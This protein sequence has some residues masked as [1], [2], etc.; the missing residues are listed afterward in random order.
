MNNTL[1]LNQTVTAGGVKT[2][3]ISGTAKDG[4]GTGI[5]SVT[6]TLSGDSEG[7][8]VTS[9]GGTWSFSG[10]VD[11]TYTVTPSKSGYTFS[12]EDAEVVISGADDATSDF[13]GTAVWTVSGDIVDGVDAGIEG[14]LVTLSGDAD[15]TD[16]TDVNGHYE[17]TGLVDG[18]YTVTPTLAN[19]AFVDASE[20]VVI[21]GG[22]E[23]VADMVGAQ[24]YPSLPIDLNWGDGSGLDT[25][26]W[27][28]Q[29]EPSATWVGNIVTPAYQGFTPS[30]AKSLRV[31]CAGDSD[32]AIAKAV[33]DGLRDNSL[34]FDKSKGLRVQFTA[35]RIEPHDYFKTYM[36]VYSTDDSSCIL[37]NY[38]TNYNNPDNLRLIENPEGIDSQ[39]SV[40][41]DETSSISSRWYTLRL[42]IDAGFV[43]ATASSAHEAGAFTTASA[44]ISTDISSVNFD[45][46]GVQLYRRG[47]GYGYWN[48]VWIGTAS[49]AWPAQ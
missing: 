2:W 38:F 43:N 18:S 34:I 19:Y 14:V 23:T 6:L 3:T 1:L 24:I 35:A 25:N 37:I 32:A 49:D 31:Q 16:T 48:R 26:V 29:S 28:D 33:Y 21:S 10:L 5:T 39:T 4:E 15:D 42:D 11:G 22:N 30:V 47:T 12:P 46:V 27:T 41:A 45:R 44:E 17:F 36:F 13:V 7:T 9:P 8:E 20:A 40:N